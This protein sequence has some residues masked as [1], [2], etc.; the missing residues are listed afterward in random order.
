M[1]SLK[2]W[3]R[4]KDLDLACCELVCCVTA[5]L[6]YEFAYIAI[7]LHYYTFWVMLFGAHLSYLQEQLDDV[8]WTTEFSDS[9]NLYIINP[10]DIFCHNFIS[11]TVSNPAYTYSRSS[12]MV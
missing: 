9:F 6:V 2:I 4:D 10:L 12:S 8:L 1:S 11:A 5:A 3:N 7:L